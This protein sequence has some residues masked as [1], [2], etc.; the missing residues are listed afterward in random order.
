M[1]VALYPHV[2]ESQIH[3]DL[4]IKF[5]KTKMFGNFDISVSKYVGGRAASSLSAARKLFVLAS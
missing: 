4:I 2:R 3:N 1:W 5:K